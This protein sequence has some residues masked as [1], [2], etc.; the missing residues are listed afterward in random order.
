MPFM[1]AEKLSSL[2]KYNCAHIDNSQFVQ[3][4]KAYDISQEQVQK[5]IQKTFSIENTF[6]NPKLNEY[7]AFVKKHKRINMTVAM[8]GF[9][10]T[11]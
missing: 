9:K 11:R 1:E 5:W 6:K 8:D 4:F 10:L 2:I 3:E 7:L